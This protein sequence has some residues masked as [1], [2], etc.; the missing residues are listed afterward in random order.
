MTDLS[1]DDK[2][3]HQRYTVN[4]SC[5]AIVNCHEY[6]GVV[7]DMPVDAAAIQ[8]DA[9]PASG[10]PIV[11]GIDDLS[12]ISAKVS[13]SNRRRYRCRVQHRPCQEEAP[14]RRTYADA[15]RQTTEGRLGGTHL[16][17]IE[18]VG[19]TWISHRARALC[20]KGCPPR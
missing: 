14:G 10:T 4:E 9:H 12:R 18:A 7:L 19:R 11:L 5:R 1:T 3:R 20:E 6:E 2:R 16:G 15:Q 17:G 13:A 8:L